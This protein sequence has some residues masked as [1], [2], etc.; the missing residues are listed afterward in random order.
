LA[1]VCFQRVASVQLLSGHFTEMDPVTIAASVLAI[2]QLTNS[3]AK[4]IA[5]LANASKSLNDDRYDELY[6]RMYAEKQSMVALLTNIEISGRPLSPENVETFQILLARLKIS[7]SKMEDALQRLLPEGGAG[8]TLRSVVTRLKFDTGGFEELK[9]R[10]SSIEAMTRALHRGN[11]P[12]MGETLP[13]YTPRAAEQSSITT[14]VS[15]VS[16]ATDHHPATPQQERGSQEIP[17]ASLCRLCEEAMV[18]LSSHPM[19]SGKGTGITGLS[20]RFELWSVGVWGSKDGLMDRIL[21][22]DPERHEVVGM[23]VAKSLVNIAVALENI[24]RAIQ[25]SEVENA[26]Q[27]LSRSRRAILAALG[28]GNLVDIAIE[29]W[30]VLSMSSTDEESMAF[31]ATTADTTADADTTKGSESAAMTSTTTE[32]A[33]GAAIG[34]ALQD[35]EFALESLFSINSSIRS[36]RRSYRLDIESAWEE[37][38]SV[39]DSTVGANS[40]AVDS[41]GQPMS[42][43]KQKEYLVLRVVSKDKAAQRLMREET[44]QLVKLLEDALNNDEASVSDQADSGAGKKMRLLSPEVKTQRLRLEEFEKNSTEIPPDKLKIAVGLNQTLK[45]TLNSVI[46]SDNRDAV[47]KLKQLQATWETDKILDRTMETLGN[48]VT[49][50]TQ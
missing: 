38:S 9:Q 48:A 26:E 5:S 16:M 20:A 4:I 36:I 19:L 8:F 35:I 2:V 46:V 42:T 27:S 7:H 29:R 30:S 23:F 6:W 28:T 49:T 22:A 47:G 14:T 43:E 32:K 33:T 21:E 10:M 13:N 31:E 44:V 15:L 24:F 39:V 17:L 18:E 50:I 11:D 3:S 1:R 37:N 41:D 25:N 40:D 12:G 34:S 45:K